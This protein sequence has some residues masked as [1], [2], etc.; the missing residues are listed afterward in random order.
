MLPTLAAQGKMI[1]FVA[2]RADCENVAELLRNN[3]SATARSG[4]IALNVGSI[5]GDKDQRERNANLSAFKKG[6]I[7]ALVA[8][9]VAARGLDVQNVT[10]VINF[11]VAKSMDGHVHRIGRA[12]RM[13]AHKNNSN[14]ITDG[15]ATHKEGVAYTLVTSKNC[16]F[17]NSLVDAFRREGREISKELLR[18]ASQSRH[19]SG[20]RGQ[21]K[22]RHKKLGLGFTEEDTQ[23]GTAHG[24]S[25]VSFE[26]K[27]PSSSRNSN[28]NSYYGPT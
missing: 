6:H 15:E 12:G 8:T 3:N 23:P 20:G 28:T 25:N 2:S 21:G 4:G 17:A 11:D 27:F 22:N 1:I 16:D 13:S 19:Y 10:T 7:H 5:H 14:G 18:V 26:S 24:Q 9:D